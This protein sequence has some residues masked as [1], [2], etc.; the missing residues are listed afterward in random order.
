MPHNSTP[1]VPWFFRHVVTQFEWRHV[2]GIA[3]IR[4]AV[5]VWL[6]FLGAILCAYGYWWGAVLFVVAG[7]IAWIV[8]QMPRW[9]VTLDAENGDATTSTA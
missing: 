5:A 1:T 9:K 4:A 3:R 6:T 7:L 8:I 2:K